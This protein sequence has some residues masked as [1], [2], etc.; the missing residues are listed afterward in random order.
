VNES[1]D[2]SDDEKLLIEKNDITTI[3]F[4]RESSSKIDYKNCEVPINEA[5]DH[6][7]NELILLAD[8]M[9]DISYSEAI[10]SLK[11]KKNIF[12]QDKSFHESGLEL[13]KN[14]SKKLNS[15]SDIDLDLCEKEASDSL[16]DFDRMDRETEISFEEFINSYN[17]KI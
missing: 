12:N 4:G 1:P 11:I 5:R 3:K 7:I 9:G 13:A 14:N 15:L 6:L 16:K 8:A 10:D 17:A 2:M